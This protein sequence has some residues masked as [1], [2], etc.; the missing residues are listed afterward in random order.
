MPMTNYTPDPIWKSKR[1]WAAVLLVLAFALEF[2]GIDL[3]PELQE[4][5]IG[6]VA[7]G[8][9]EIGALITIVLALLSKRNE[10]R[11]GQPE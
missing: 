2:I 10:K 8:Y 9:A 6:H 11:K 5:I 1:L 4:Q 7:V 3:T